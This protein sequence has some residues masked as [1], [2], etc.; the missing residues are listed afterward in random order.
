M[1]VTQ[2]YELILLCKEQD[3]AAKLSLYRAYDGLVR[4]FYKG[5]ICHHP[6]CG[7]DLNDY[8]Q[9]AY[10][11]FCK[12]V[13]YIDIAKIDRPESWLFLGY[14]VY[15][16]K[17][18]NSRL[19]KRAT[20]SLIAEDSIDSLYDGE[21][22]I[23]QDNYAA[24]ATND[25]ASDMGMQAFIYDTFM[26]ALTEDERRVVMG[27]MRLN[28]D[29]REMTLKEIAKEMGSNYAAVYRKLMSAK[30]VYEKL[31]SC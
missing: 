14:Y 30:Q 1:S 12:A 13:K 5:F 15:A 4:K 22:Y 6:M 19:G 3:E 31:C 16:L 10:F 18:L 11:A 2:D 23:N 21:G 26:G 27:K 9:E 17:N 25:T 24:L 7:L 29:N 8:Q 20:K 28:T